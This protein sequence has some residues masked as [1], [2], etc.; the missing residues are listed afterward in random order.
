MSDSNLNP[1][2][3]IEE[4]CKRL[5][6]LINY[7]PQKKMS[8]L[9][10]DLKADELLQRLSKLDVFK[11]SIEALMAGIPVIIGVVSFVLGS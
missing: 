6:L 2:A 1:D 8:E 7:F 5:N 11:G 9:F 4:L 3:K 10:N